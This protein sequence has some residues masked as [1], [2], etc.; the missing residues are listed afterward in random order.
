MQCDPCVLAEMSGMAVSRGEAPHVLE[1]DLNSSSVR[2]YVAPSSRQG[3]LQVQLRR[4]LSR[5]VH[6]ITLK[7]ASECDLGAQRNGW[8]P[9]FHRP[10][11]HMNKLKFFLIFVLCKC[12]SSEHLVAGF[13]SDRRIVHLIRLQNMPPQHGLWLIT[14]NHDI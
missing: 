13:A 11:G 5:Y 8:L 6:S 7:I 1:T 2:M 12:R 9:Q 10:P 14:T 4:F 3:C